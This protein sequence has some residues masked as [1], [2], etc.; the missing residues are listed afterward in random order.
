MREIKFRAWDGKKFQ[1]FTIG[2]CWGDADLMVYHELVL[3]GIKFEQFTGLHDKN[4]KE[5]YDGDIVKYNEFALIIKYDAVHARFALYKDNI[6][7]AD[8]GV[9]SSFK[10]EIIGNIHENP[11]LIKNEEIKQ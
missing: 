3:N 1:Y 8:F 10:C 4:G 6:F 2:Q 7:F 11:E 5:I 9:Q